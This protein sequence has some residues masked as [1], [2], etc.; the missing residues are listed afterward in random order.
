MKSNFVETL[1]HTTR[2]SEPNPPRYDSF[3]PTDPEQRAQLET[4]IEQHLSQLLSDPIGVRRMSNAFARDGYLKFGANELLSATLTKLLRQ[5]AYS[6]LEGHAIRRDVRIQET[7]L[8]GRFMSNVIQPDIR[9]HGKTIPLIYESP[10]LRNFLGTIAGDELANCWEEEWYLI[11]R[12]EKVGDTHGWH[13]GDYPYTVIWIVEAPEL[14]YGGMLQCIPHTVWDKKN[15]Q[16]NRYIVDNPIR[17]YHHQTAEAYFLKSDT[18]LHRVVPL[19]RD[20]TRI[21]LNT[22]WASAN[23]RRE[24]IDHGTMTAAFTTPTGT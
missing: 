2:K 15:P 13:W 10:S 5:D 22:C 12:L 14:E 23:D 24:H 7:D 18:T 3:D 17:S 16:V 6:L 1:E 9:K 11:N 8:S 19:N 20:I 21:I 4:L